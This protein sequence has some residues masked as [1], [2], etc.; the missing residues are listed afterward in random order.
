MLNADKQGPGRP[1]IEPGKPSR[2]WPVRVGPSL[3][4]KA[5]RIALTRGVSVPAVIRRALERYDPDEDDDY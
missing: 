5:A 4:D 3:D 1:S 2:T